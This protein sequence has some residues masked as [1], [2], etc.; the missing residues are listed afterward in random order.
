MQQ[1]M[2]TTSPAAKTPYASHAFADDSAIPR[3][4][5][6]IRRV[7]E[8]ITA[9]PVRGSLSAGT[10]PSGGSVFSAGR[11]HSFR[12]PGQGLDLFRD[13]GIE[14][15]GAFLSSP[16]RDAFPAVPGAVVPVGPSG[17]GGAL[18][19]GRWFPTG[20]ACSDRSSSP[21]RVHGQA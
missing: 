19:T 17:R 5:Q 6:G 12:R 2:W 10:L 14:L 15:I 1:S 21:R 4:K 11:V 16:V 3:A 20:S 7:V 9:G 18:G 8:E 13:G